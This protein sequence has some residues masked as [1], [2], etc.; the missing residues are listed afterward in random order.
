M[1]NNYYDATGVLVLDR[2]TPVIRAL[3]GGFNLDETY[4]GDGKV[5][6]ARISESNDPQWDDLLETLTDLAE[7][8]DLASQ[9]TDDEPPTVASVLRA[10]SRHFGTDNSEALNQ[11]IDND[12]FDGPADLDALFLIATHF[13]DGH[14]LVEL[15]MQG[16]WH[17]S[18]PRL[19]EFG[20]DGCF[21]SRELSLFSAS[22][23]VLYLGV[24]LRKALLANDIQTSAT[25]IAQETL[26]LLCAI[27][28]DQLRKQLHRRVIWHL[29]ESLS[30]HSA[31]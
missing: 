8:L 15:H 3:F 29:I 22:E 27:S 25:Q 24:D 26:D 18:K 4:P 10:L 9:A 23:H 14:N 1:A 12:P 19:F 30:D 17:C 2:V 13:D 28:D 31:E 16:C 11:L 21:L 20:G 7:Q 5:Y 6:I